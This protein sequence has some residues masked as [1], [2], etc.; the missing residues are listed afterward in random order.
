MT[1]LCGIQSGILVGMGLPAGDREL[2]QIVDAALAGAALRAG[3][4]LVCRLGCTQCCYGAFVISELDA[5][6]LGAGMETLRREKPALAAEIERRAQMWIGT[7]GADF[8]G[9]LG[10]GRL[11]D[12]DADRERFAEFANEAACPALDPATGRCDVYE[13]R[14]MTCRVF[15]PPIQMDGGKDGGKSLGHCELC[16][17]GA[18]EDEVVGCEMPVPDELEKELLAGIPE[19]CETLVAFALLR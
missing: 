6:R 8:P 7:H 11:G 18:T 19:K 1:K 13:W 17:V 14:P 10:T 15:G 5:L 16:F 4:W 12:S 2:V 9:D 3:A